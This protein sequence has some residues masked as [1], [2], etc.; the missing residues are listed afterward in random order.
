M[1]LESLGEGLRALME[2]KSWSQRH[3]SKESGVSENSLSDYLS[4][5]YMPALKTLDKLLCAGGWTLYDLAK[6]MGLARP[7]QAA[8]E[9]AGTRERLLAG[10]IVR[11]EEKIEELE[12]RAEG[13]E[14]GRPPA[15]EPG[16]DQ[17]EG[18]ATRR[19]R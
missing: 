11:L 15:S 19:R 12:G 10:V 13:E 3:W 1:S 14:E 16:G 2:G 9:A 7:E 18:E 8:S 5:R 4:G 17:G 6:A